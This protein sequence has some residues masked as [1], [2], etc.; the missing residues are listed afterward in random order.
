MVLF[1][2]VTTELAEEARK[3]SEKIALLPEDQWKNVDYESNTA[4]STIVLS[5]IPREITVSFC[6]ALNKTIVCYTLILLCILANMAARCEM[7]S[8]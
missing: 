7:S 2:L 5:H 1:K 4:R 8:T 6:T 3:V